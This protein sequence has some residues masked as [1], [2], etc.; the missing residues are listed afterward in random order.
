MGLNLMAEMVI[1]CPGLNPGAIILFSELKKTTH[2]S[3]LNKFIK[4]FL[5]ICLVYGGLWLS[6][7]KYKMKII[8]C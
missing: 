1:S 3:T 5:R 4:L 7:R 6:Q 2:R 8:A